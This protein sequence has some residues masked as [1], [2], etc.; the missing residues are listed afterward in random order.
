ML[1]EKQLKMSQ[2]AQTLEL[3]KIL[4]KVD[5]CSK[6]MYILS[7]IGG[8]WHEKVVSV[9]GFGHSKSLLFVPKSE[10]FCQ[11]CLSLS[12]QAEHTA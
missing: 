6:Q 4:L 3:A 11:K 5:N 12:A 1:Q 8:H 9:F 10:H 2:K 7:F